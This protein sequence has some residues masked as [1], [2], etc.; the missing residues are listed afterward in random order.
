VKRIG[1]GVAWALGCFCALAC[2]TPARDFLAAGGSA[3]EA[4]GGA[5]NF[6]GRSGQGAEAAGRAAG[7]SDVEAGGGVTTNGGRAEMGGDS[8]G[9]ASGGTAPSSGGTAPSSGGASCVVSNANASTA[10]N[11]G[12]LWWFDNCGAR[13]TVKQDCCDQGCNANA[14]VAPNAHAST[15]C[16]GSNE[17]WVDSCGVRTAKKTDC[18]GMGCASNQCNAPNPMA[19]KM[20]SNGDVYWVDSCGAQQQLAT[21]CAG[22]GCETGACLPACPTDMVSASARYCIDRYEAS[23]WSASNCTGT[24][25]FKSSG[26][27]PTSFPALASSAGLSGAVQVAGSSYTLSAPTA[28]LYACSKTGV[29]PAQYITYFQAKRACENS[30]KRLCTLAEQQTACG[31]IFPYGSTYDPLACNGADAGKGAVVAAGSMTRCEG[32]VPGLYDMSGNV[33]EWAQCDAQNCW[34]SSGTFESGESVLKCSYYSG[35]YASSALVGEG[36][37]CCRDR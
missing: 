29:V 7:G 16:F 26:D 4:A 2:S 13:A 22:N 23:V 12:D 35:T 37:R 32:S 11:S 24:A 30:G 33:L 15:Q 5:S 34:R 25:Y 18:C 28:T 17:Y 21:G 9:A 1:L 14:C 31:S 8:A 20:C 10:C 36:F 6:G 3:G 19:S 27:F